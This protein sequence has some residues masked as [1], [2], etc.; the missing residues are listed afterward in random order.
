MT[1]AAPA[2]DRRSPAGCRGGSRCALA[3]G[4]ARAAAPAHGLTRTDGP[5]LNGALAD[6]GP[7]ARRL[8][9]AAVGRACC[10]REALAAAPV[11]PAAR[12]VRDRGRRGVR[13]RAGR[14]AAGGRRRHRRLGR[15]RAARALRRRGRGRRGRRAARGPARPRRPAAGPR[16]VGAGGAGPAGPAARPAA[17]RAGGRRDPREPDAARGTAR[18]GGRAPRERGLREGYSCFKVKVGLPDDA[19]RVAAV[20]EAI[21]PWPA[22][23]LDANGAWARR[24][25]GGGHRPTSRPTTSSSSSSR[26]RRLEEMAEVRA[27][28]GGADGRRRVDRGAADVRAAAEL[29]A[30][31]A[32]NVKLA[33]SGG[34]G[35]A[36]EALRDGAR[37]RAGRVAVEHARRALGNRRGAAARCLRAP[38]ARVRAR[39]ARRCSTPRSRGPCPARGGPDAGAPGPGPR[40]GGLGRQ[41]W[42][43]C[44]VEE[45]RRSS[46]ATASGRWSWAACPAPSTIAARPSGRP[47]AIRRRGLASSARPGAGDRQ[48]RQ[49]RASGRRS[50]TGS[51]APWPAVRSSRARSRGSWRRRP[52]RCSSTSASDWS[53]NSGWRSQTATISLDLLASPSTRPASRRPRARAARGAGRPRCPAEAP[54]VTS[55]RVARRGRAA[56]RAGRAGRRAS[57]RSSTAPSPAAAISASRP[58]KVCAAWSRRRLG[59]AF[60]QQLG[61]RRPRV[62]GLHEA[63]DEDHRGALAAH[64]A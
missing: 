48:Q 42:P 45:V 32:V 2:G 35:P 64:P 10:S 27:A 26:A 33:G 53:A 55:A 23:R 50:Q 44:C 19:E 31:D 20:R 17:R 28:G 46:A 22:L 3:V 36:R 9:A 56:R 34:F 21:G 59:I 61:H 62:A 13:P 47:R 24:R 52:G 39:D 49:A 12:A 63:G 60:G 15:G 25:G 14:D 11:D 57:S 8:L 4:A 58:S 7:P 5:S 41:A 1:F 29:E 6:T 37:Q 30:C 38:A 40:R 51:S 16:R 54:T 43:R 18:G